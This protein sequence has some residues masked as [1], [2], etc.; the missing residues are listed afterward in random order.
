MGK[1]LVALDLDGTLFDSRKEVTRDT[2][3][4]LELFIK[5]GNEVVI[6]TG[7]SF[8]SIPEN[9][10]EIQGIRYAICS[11]GASLY[12]YETGECLYL[13]SMDKNRAT[14]FLKDVLEYPVMVE[15]FMGRISVLDN[16]N[17]GIIEFMALPKS[18]IEFFKKVRIT[19]D[20]LDEYI[21]TVEEGIQKIAVNFKPMEDGSYY[22]REKIVEVAKK[23]P[24]FV[25]VSGGLANL[26][27]TNITAT[28]G[29][30]LLRLANL[31]NIDVTE[32]YA[33]GDSEN[34]KEMIIKANTGVAMGNAT[35]EIKGI[36]NFI[37]KS[38]NEDGIAFALIELGLI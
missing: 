7:R 2:K 38:N 22:C 1:K 11:N 14:L 15:A 32:T 29:N 23:Y 26:E 36:A 17:C 4:K 31:L 3:E 33:F 27:V 37:T 9:I 8:A 19:V 35:D 28:K 21:F 13:D 30:A 20:R 18:A 12:N 34:D 6:A 24:D 25:A 16:K 5:N 10:K